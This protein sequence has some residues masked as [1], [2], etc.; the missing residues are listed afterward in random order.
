MPAMHTK[1][2]NPL[3]I[4]EHRQLGHEISAANARLRE[5][6]K[7]VVT[8]YGPQNR[9]AFSFLKAADAVERLC[10]ELQAQVVKDHPGYSTEKFYR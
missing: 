2:S 8:V 10:H 3:S 5:L 6:C 1:L 4:E 9:A 7:L